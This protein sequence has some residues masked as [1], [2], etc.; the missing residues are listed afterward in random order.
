MAKNLIPGM[1]IR[2]VWDHYETYYNTD[3]EYVGSETMYGTIV[4]FD[5]NSAEDMRLKEDGCIKVDVHT[6]YNNFYYLASDDGSIEV[7]DFRTKIKDILHK[8][9]K[10]K[11]V[12]VK[13]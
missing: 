2:F 4:E 11:L 3:V 6:K 13:R 5:E 7:L 1:N 9:F 8:I 10:Y 12:L